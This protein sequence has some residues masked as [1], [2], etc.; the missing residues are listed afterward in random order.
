MYVELSNILVKAGYAGSYKVLVTFI[1]FK[2]FSEFNTM[3]L[4]P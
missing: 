1:S 2:H 3:P 4:F